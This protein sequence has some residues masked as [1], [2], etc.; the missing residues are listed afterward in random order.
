V[1]DLG[2]LTDFLR[3][4]NGAGFG[5]LRQRQHRRAD[6]MRPAPRPRIERAPQR[7]GGDLAGFAGKAHELDPTAEE[8]GRAAFVG[9]DVRL[10]MAEHGAPRRGEMRQ[11][12]R[13][14]RRSGRH[15]EDRD[16]AL[17]NFREARLHAPRPG[18]VA[19][20]ERSA[21]I[22]ARNG[23]KDLGRDPGRVVTCEIHAA[24]LTRP[25]IG[26]VNSV[27]GA[28]PQ[29]CSD[30]FLGTDEETSNAKVDFLDRRTLAFMIRI[31]QG[32]VGQYCC[33]NWRP[34]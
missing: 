31:W 32:K 26:R 12:E 24:S 28:R 29:T 9:C 5:C 6:V 15:Q 4:V 18:I 1:G 30:G 3:P 21:G 10:L 19:V 8:F 23:G 2:K 17:E 27:P 22:R 20:S 14:C 16:L 25:R 11:R 34:A 33:P 7:I 13:V